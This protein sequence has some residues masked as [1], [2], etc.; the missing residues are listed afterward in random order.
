M[1]TVAYMSP[2]QA[3]GEELDRRS[4]LF[5]FGALL[6]EMATGR[7]A[8]SGATMAAIHDA[9]LHKA[10]ISPVRL[11]PELPAKLEEIIHKALEKDREVRYQHAS[12][13]RADL[14]RLKRD[15]ESGK[16]TSGATSVAVPHSDI[17]KLILRLA[18]A[19]LVALLVGLALWYVFFYQSRPEPETPLS[20]LPLTSY[21][22]FER[23]PT[24]S[25]DGNQVA[26]CWNGEKQDNDDIY[27]K[28]I[29]SGTQ[30]RL[31]TAP[32][33]DFNPAWSPDGRSIAFVREWPG[34]KASV[35]LM[36]SLGPPER[37]VAVISQARGLA[38]TPDG[39]SLVVTD[40]NSDN[41]PLGLFLLSVESDERRRLT[42]APE[43]RFVD[44]EPAFSPDGGKL[45]FVREVGSLLVRDIYLLALSEDF[46]P[47]GEPKRLTFEN[48]LT[49]TPVWTPDGR[50]VVFSSGTW[51][52]LSLFRI[53]ASGSGKPERLGA[54][55]EDGVEPAISRH[56]HRLAYTRGLFDINIWR[57]EVPG[58][59]GKVGSPMKLIDST[60]I[61]GSAEFSP[62]GKRIA[63]ASDRTGRVEIWVCDNDGSRAVQ[64]TSLGRGFA[65][66]PRWSPDG[67]RIAFD[68]NVEGQWEI[69]LI[70]AHGGKPKRLTNNPA[71][72]VVPSWSQDGKWVYFNS[73][74]SGENQVWKVPSGGG[75]AVVVTRQGGFEAFESHDGKWLYYTKN[76]WASSLWTV[77]TEGGEEAQVLE[78][79][80][81]R[82]FAVAKE[83][84][85]FIPRPDSARRYSIQFFNSAT[86]RTRP[87]A[88]IEKPVW[89][90]LSVSPD[91]RWIL[92]SQVDQG[93]SDLILVENF[94]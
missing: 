56:G 77:P 8:F 66:T 46:Q 20:V 13:L 93:G 59:H 55:G 49:V 25:P 30:L 87:I 82:A 61:D 58:A 27:V 31:T 79:V 9:I 45:A 57:V 29:G 75:E 23:Q 14:K 40:R 53:A 78:S 90:Y 38:W 65:G 3:L 86:K 22:G 18:A 15:T 32:E 17:R 44:S 80:D 26:F 62:D 70:S 7:L 84:I 83:G 35:F 33:A 94:R 16:A 73:N 67:E 4:D 92:Y 69:Y 89:M 72:D 34:G 54:F 10:P 42:S 74:R 5:S 24:F 1:G 41:E 81:A 21:P 71:S 63:F 37:K 51:A 60:R 50:E 28:L 36:S 39:K 12:E 91:G 85:Y 52:N 76:D 19:T 11:N 68:W 43:K 6:Y 48:Q 2:E 64:L 88:T 47:I